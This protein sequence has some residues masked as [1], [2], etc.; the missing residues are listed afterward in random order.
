MQLLQ[1]LPFYLFLGQFLPDLDENYIKIYLKSRTTRLFVLFY[2]ICSV[3]NDIYWFLESKVLQ[4]MCYI[5]PATRTRKNPY[6][7]LRVR[8]ST[9][10]GA[11]CP[12][13]PQGGPRHSLKMSH[14]HQV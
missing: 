11:G 7:W 4:P 8:V 6:P 1:F 13:K 5:K 3:V 2:F 14:F 10:T 12:K 9:G